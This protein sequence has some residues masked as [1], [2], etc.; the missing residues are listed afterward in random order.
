MYF[1][2]TLKIFCHKSQ[3]IICFWTFQFHAHQDVFIS[4]VSHSSIK[5]SFHFQSNTICSKFQAFPCR[6]LS[7]SLCLSDFLWI[8]VVFLLSV[9]E[10]WHI[11][12]ARWFKISN[13]M[14]FFDSE[15]QL[16]LYMNWQKISRFGSNSFHFFCLQ[17]SFSVF[18]KHIKIV[19]KPFSRKI[20]KTKVTITGPINEKQKNAFQFE[21]ISWNNRLSSPKKGILSFFLI[22]FFC[23][24]KLNK[25]PLFH[26]IGRW[27]RLIV[28]S[29]ILW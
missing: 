23:L 20:M 17:I 29:N 26:P 8:S 9:K 27:M 5:S 10:W 15:F 1:N 4:F 28:T 14:N 22:G 16:F 21:T 24:I 3:F 2:V 12:Y 7:V 19:G 13:G 6:S 11:F 25:F 18:R